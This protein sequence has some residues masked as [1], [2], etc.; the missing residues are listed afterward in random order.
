MIH[1]AKTGDASTADMASSDQEVLQVK[2]G[3]VIIPS[4][5]DGTCVHVLVVGVRSPRVVV[6][7]Q[8]TAL[9]ERGQSPERSGGTGSRHDSV[10]W[11]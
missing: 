9:V 8:R 5:I 1:H 7:R 3:E 4:R 6:G 2:V 11:L 10:G